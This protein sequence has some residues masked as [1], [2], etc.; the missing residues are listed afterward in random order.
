MISNIGPKQSRRR[1]YFGILALGVTIALLII[2]IMNGLSRWW[3]LFLFVPFTM[4]SLGILQFREKT[5]VALASQ[6]M[7]NMDDT[8]LRIDDDEQYR[9]IR[10]KARQINLQAMLS[11]FILTILSLTL[12]E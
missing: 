12:P 3:R 2:L 10:E 4:G 1:L 9:L 11:G 5:C 6:R 7:M 8:D